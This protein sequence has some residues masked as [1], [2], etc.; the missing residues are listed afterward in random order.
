MPIT[1]MVEARR[2]A[3]SVR[4]ERIPPAGFAAGRGASV[5][6]GALARAGS[7][8]ATNRRGSA[9]GGRVEAL[10]APGGGT[11]GR[12]GPTRLKETRELPGVRWR[13]NLVAFIPGP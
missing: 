1:A 6:S 5:V 7:D 8:A 3:R 2:P 9:G 12:P 13:Q 11:A 10:V 4:H